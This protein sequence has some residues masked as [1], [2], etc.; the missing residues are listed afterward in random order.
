L[1][2]AQVGASQAAH[3]TEDIGPADADVEEGLPAG[4]ADAQ[5][6]AL[7]A[8]PGDGAAEPLGGFLGGHEFLGEFEHEALRGGAPLG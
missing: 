7:L 2:A 3:L 1:D 6:F 8:D 5:E 4:A